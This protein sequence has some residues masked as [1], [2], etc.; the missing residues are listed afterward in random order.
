[1][2]VSPGPSPLAYAVSNGGTI[3]LDRSLG[4]APAPVKL[5]LTADVTFLAPPGWP[6]EPGATGA[7]LYI[8]NG[9]VLPAG[10]TL[11]FLSS[12][13]AALIAA[14]VGEVTP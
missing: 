5:T 6:T 1:M 3:Y 11:F 14:N 8:V 12:S 9:T 4:I 13:A 2:S 7:P 10:T